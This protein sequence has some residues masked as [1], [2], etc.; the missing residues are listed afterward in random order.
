[1]HVEQ[2]MVRGLRRLGVPLVL[3]AS[4]SPSE[5]DR[6]ELVR[7]KVSRRLCSLKKI[8]KSYWGVQSQLL[9][10]SCNFQQQSALVSLLYSVIGWEHPFGGVT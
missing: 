3:H 8:Q 1:M 10:E 5:G 9:V 6:G 2:T 4:L 7:Q